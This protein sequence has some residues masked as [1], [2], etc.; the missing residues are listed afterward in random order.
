MSSSV[1][2]ANT[3]SPILV[4]EYQ[5]LDALGGPKGLGGLQAVA[6]HLSERAQHRHHRLLRQRSCRLAL[7][8]RQVC[9]QVGHGVLT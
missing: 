4:D 1:P 5:S 7:A 2:H 6:Q 9:H 8:T 3:L